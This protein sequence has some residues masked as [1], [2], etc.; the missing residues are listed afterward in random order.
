MIGLADGRIAGLVLDIDVTLDGLG[1]GYG[2]FIVAVIGKGDLERF[3]QVYHRRNLPGKLRTFGV[4]AALDIE[5]ADIRRLL[6]IHDDRAGRSVNLDTLLQADLEIRNAGEDDGIIHI[7]AQAGRGSHEQQQRC[8]YFT[9][10]SHSW[11]LS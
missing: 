7:V 4:N 8:R 11:Q 10:Q 5:G 1:S 2:P 6:K 3:A 9:Q